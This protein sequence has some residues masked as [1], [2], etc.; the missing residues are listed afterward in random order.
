MRVFRRYE[1]AY[2]SLQGERVLVM[3]LTQSPMWTKATIVGKDR[4]HGQGVIYCKVKSDDLLPI[5]SLNE[6]S[7]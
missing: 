1:K 2:A 6:W 3:V 4:N 5:P 7:W